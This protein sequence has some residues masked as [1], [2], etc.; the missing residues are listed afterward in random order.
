MV[1]SG[2]PL[3]GHQQQGREIRPQVEIGMLAESFDGV[4]Q[5]WALHVMVEC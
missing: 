4:C 1:D 3:G 2:Q 5:P